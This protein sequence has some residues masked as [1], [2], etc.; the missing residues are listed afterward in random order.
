MVR[1]NCGHALAHRVSYA[2]ANNREESSLKVIRHTC[3]NP[4]C[5]NPEHLIE[6]TQLENTLDRVYR[7]CGTSL[8]LEQ[9]LEIKELLKTK[10]KHWIA[11]KFNVHERTIR[12]IKSGRTWKKAIEFAES[13]K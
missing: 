8:K 12:D 13:Q 7:T 10:N 6:G 5:I 2:V 3:D 9:V 4:A 1:F 11:A